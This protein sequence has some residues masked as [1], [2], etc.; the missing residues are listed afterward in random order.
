ML[1]A[2]PRGHAIEVRLYAEDPYDGF[3]P[4]TGQLTAWRPPAGPGVRVDS[5]VEEG[6]VLRTEYD[7]LLAK[8][9]V[10]AGTR[11][12]ALA[13]LRRALDELA[14]GG[15]QTDAGFLRWLVDEPGFASG[16]YDTGLIDERWSGGPP[17][18]SEERS[19]AA[20]VA[21]WAREASRETAEPPRGAASGPSESAWAR[22]ARAEALR[23]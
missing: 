6:A 14:V 23:R 11:A 16:D 20:L 7:P 4:T 1:A 13:R 5:G 10:H 3:R 19:L 18:G 21:L 17:L 12:E 15:V 2:L 8:I 9:M 22:R